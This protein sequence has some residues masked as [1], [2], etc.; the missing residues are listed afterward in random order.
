MVGSGF[1]A[2]VH[3]PA[4]RGAGIEVVSL[5]G[6]QAERTRRRAERAGI[7]HA[8]VDLADAIG[9]AG[10]QCPLI[11]SIA[12]PPDTHAGLAHQALAAGCHVICEKPFTVDGGEARDLAAHARAAGAVAVVGHEFRWAPERA[13][14]ARAI[15]QGCLGT[16]RLFSLVSHVGLVAGASSPAPPWWFDP[17]RGGGWLGASGSHAIDQ[18]RSWLGE[19][20]SV[21]AGLE[22]VGPR[23][24]GGAE[25]TFTIR[26]RLAGGAEGIV[27][28]T[29]AAWGA[30]VGMTRVIGD[31]A[32]VWLDGDH[33]WL[34]DADGERPLEIPQDLLLAPA[35]PSDDPRHRFTHLEL[36]PYTRMASWV[37]GAIL[38]ERPWPPEPVAVPGAVPL[39]ATFDDASRTMEVLDA[40]R[41]SARHDGALVSI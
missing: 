29:A 4:L 13:T 23:A 20:R 24:S 17:A 22:S 31:R 15:A 14:L 34:A 26:L 33:V 16:P 32:A 36:G 2:R 21:S 41:H 10:D 19:V 39:P 28:Q 7:D 12:T 27:Q 9:R 6:Q 25:D 3:V 11:V 38:G 35:A 30:P 18:L 5:V 1:G 40:V 37:V 8:T